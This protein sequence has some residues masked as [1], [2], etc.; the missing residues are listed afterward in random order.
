MSIGKKPSENKYG[1]VFDKKL[2]GRRK[3]IELINDRIY[4]KGITIIKGPSRIGKTWLAKS[5]I[6]DAIKSDNWVFGYAELCDRDFFL[7]GLKNLFINFFNDSSYSKQAKYLIKNSKKDL[8]KN[9][10]KSLVT[11][12]EIFTVG[13]DTYKNLFDKA[14]NYLMF[15][16]SD[17]KKGPAD[18]PPLDYDQFFDLIKLLS[19][20][21]K[22]D[23]FLI[24]L[25]SWEGRRNSNEGIAILK[26]FLDNLEEWPHVHIIITINDSPKYNHHLEYL[27]DLSKQM[28][29]DKALLYELKQIQLDYS[30]ENELYK[31]IIDQVPTLKKFSQDEIISYIDGYPLIIE[32]L[33]TI[34]QI[35]NDKFS[36]DDLQ[37]IKNEALAC[38]YTEF[39]QIIPA[40]DD[41]MLI[42]I[43]KLALLPEIT[44]LEQW[45][46]LKKLVV[47][48]DDSVDFA[49]QLDTLNGLKIFDTV[50]PF[51][52]FGHHTR[53]EA[54]RNY[55]FQN[56]ITLLQELFHEVFNSMVSMVKGYTEEYSTFIKTLIF[57]EKEISKLSY[58]K[59]F[60]LLCISA[61]TLRGINDNTETMKDI[62]KLK[63]LKT[64]ALEKESYVPLVSMAFVNYYGVFSDQL[65]VN[66]EFRNYIN[67][68]VRDLNT[69]YPNM[70]VIGMAI[71]KLLFIDLVKSTKYSK[72]IDLQTIFDELLSLNKNFPDEIEIAYTLTS[73]M[74]DIINYWEKSEIDDIDRRINQC[75][76][77]LQKSDIR[78]NLS[79]KFK[80]DPKSPFIARIYGK[81]IFASLINIRYENGELIE[82]KLKNFDLP[83]IERS[84]VE[85][86]KIV[87]S[88][89]SCY[90]LYFY[91]LHCLVSESR[92]ISDIENYNKWL[93]EFLLV[94]DDMQNDRNIR[95]FYSYIVME[96]INA[97]HD[98]QLSISCED[99][100]NK[101]YFTVIRHLTDRELLYRY[102]VFAL[103]QCEDK[104]NGD[105]KLRYKLLNK[106][107]VI[108]SEIREPLIY[109]MYCLEITKTLITDYRYMSDAKIKRLLSMSQ[110]SIYGFISPESCRNFTYELIKQMVNKVKAGEKTHSGFYIYILN[111]I[112]HYFRN[113]QETL[114]I[115]HIG[116]YMYFAFVWRFIDINKRN[117]YLS[118]LQYYESYIHPHSYLGN[119]IDVGIPP[120][121]SLKL[122]NSMPDK[123]AESC[124]NEMGQMMYTIYMSMQ[125]QDVD[126]GQ[127]FTEVFGDN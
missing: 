102:I 77:L 75:H 53:Y 7:Y 57:F 55:F 124:L 43:S 91:F 68:A 66:E 121:E 60:N 92:K 28:G 37:V 84:I 94:F 101:L 51:P 112:S 71:S 10:G 107:Y 46:D 49:I 45:T 108:Q 117:K 25:D 14:I 69:A 26:K 16:D 40:L 47:S 109:E 90:N 73:M 110:N 18:L 78:S 100:L 76:A 58:N 62:N 35:K 61:Q 74:P 52:S 13:H 12:L 99:L 6:Y 3:D 120:I 96:G 30:E 116:L 19:N 2:F 31:F 93:D 34:G 8:L 123:N 82:M 95:K 119:Q 50:H 127:K 79:K 22:S 42:I 87:K 125:A 9:L 1:Y 122:F 5:I 4:S 115:I 97:F 65:E 114:S 48:D 21:N 32:R 70:P 86:R 36:K 41:R 20:V 113:D 27:Y 54:L 85:F 81:S 106:I 118:Y 64:S 111:T 80:N 103:S 23:K 44:S 98:N 126:W 83:L 29:S 104:K 63:I 72:N 105:Y 17:I 89:K 56:K 33:T 11:I 88:D 39:D 59:T 67:K 38:L 15:L 24:V